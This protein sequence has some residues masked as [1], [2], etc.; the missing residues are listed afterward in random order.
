MWIQCQV[1][2]KDEQE[3]NSKTGFYHDVYTINSHS[4]NSYLELDMFKTI[5]SISW[6]STQLPLNP[7]PKA[8]TNIE[9]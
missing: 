7:I 5:D 9:I 4:N 3:S 8:S 2:Q 1:E 6:N